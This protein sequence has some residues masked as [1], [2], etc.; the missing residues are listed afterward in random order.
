MSTPLTLHSQS[1]STYASRCPR[2]ISPLPLVNLNSSPSTT[3]TLLSFQGIAKTLVNSLIIL[4]LFVHSLLPLRLNSQLAL[5]HTHSGLLPRLLYST[6]LFYTT[7]NQ[8]PTQWLLSTCGLTSSALPA[9]DRSRSTATPTALKRAECPTSKRLPPLPARRPARPASLPSPTPDQA[10]SPA[11]LLPPS[12][13]CLPPTTS[14]RPSPTAQLLARHRRLAA[15]CPTC[16]LSL[17]TGASPPR[18][19]TA[20][21]APCRAYPL[22]P[23]RAS[24][25]TRHAWNCEHT[26]FHSSRS[27]CSAGDHT[28]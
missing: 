12:S 5:A 16:P 21:S 4:W 26:L 18:A 13:S 27:D 1:S 17:P 25:Q 6:L 9:T 15:T 3:L 11:D 23:R 19:H 2:F 14:T 10:A 24:C 28:K 8:P 7:T 20:A 22:P